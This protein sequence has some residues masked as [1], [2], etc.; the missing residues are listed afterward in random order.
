LPPGRAVIAATTRRESYRGNEQT[1]ME[2]PPSSKIEQLNYAL[3]PPPREANPRRV[4]MCLL[5]GA[6]CIAAT[7]GSRTIEGAFPMGDS[8]NFGGAC[9]ML[10][11]APL[12][13]VFGIIA[14]RE[15]LRPRGLR[16]L[17]WGVGWNIIV[18]SG[19]CIAIWAVIRFG[20]LKHL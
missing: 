19:P 1:D 20:L 8:R 3:P 9:L 7:I 2:Q 4:F 15:A 13:L 16:A 5:P 17:L 6:I 18:A 14:I 12:G 11:T 10:F